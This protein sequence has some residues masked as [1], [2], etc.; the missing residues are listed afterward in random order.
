MRITSKMISSTYLRNLNGLATDLN[1]YNNQ[2]ASGREFSKAAE[3]PASAVRAYRL[4]ENLSRINGYSSN[5]TYANSYLTNAE[6][7]LNGMESTLIE[8][9]AKILQALNGTQSQNERRI[10][11]TELRS[12]QEQLL[13]SLNSNDFGI[14]IFG[15]SNTDSKP[16]STGDSG[17]LVYNGYN[18]ADMNSNVTLPHTLEEIDW[19]NSEYGLNTTM[20]YRYDYVGE[21]EEVARPS[22]M[23]DPTDTATYPLGESDPAYTADMATYLASVATEPDPTDT[24][25]YPGGESDAAYITDKQNYDEYKS[26]D[27]YQN[28]LARRD[29]NRDAFAKNTLNYNLTD[30]SADD[31][32]GVIDEV[33]KPSAM[34]LVENYVSDAEFNKAMDEYIESV[35]VAPVKDDYDGGTES[36]AYKKALNLYKL[37]NEYPDSTDTAKYPL[38][39]SDPA[40]LADVAAYEAGMPNPSDYCSGNN[41]T[42]WEEDLE[43]YRVSYMAANAAPD[44]TDTSLYPLGEADPAYVADLAAYNNS[45]DAA[46][47][48]YSTTLVPTDSRYD[49][50]AYTAATAKYAVESVEYAEYKAYDDAVTQRDA[51]RDAVEDV[52]AAALQKRLEDDTLYLD[53]GLDVEFANDGQEVVDSSVFKYSLT[54]LMVMKAG[55]TTV[56][57]DNGLKT[58]DLEVANNLYDM[59]G[60]LVKEFEKPD[61][62][63]SYDAANAIYGVFNDSTAVVVN[64]MTLIGTKSSYLDFTESRLDTLTLNLQERQVDVEGVDSYKAIINFK[65]TQ[66]SQQAALQMGNYII[67]SSIFDYLS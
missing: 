49:P 4:R 56:S 23:P 45:V 67:Q 51:N 9:K 60:Q 20:P 33:A 22:A 54:G 42:A 16:F 28:L 53:I 15:G 48:A 10:I 38:G 63:Y 11:A 65:T 25:T 66:A 40:Y 5:V 8:S 64:N 58:Y 57:V 37:E 1:K 59:L 27:I 17:Q 52:R 62:E 32:I 55:T 6:S 29:A 14:Y 50:A 44:P 43:A 24:A 26:Y 47:S 34:P 21:L 35:T 41:S 39:E 3:D 31:Y 12:V 7:V 19:A 36:V 18:V 13:Q 61:S 30:P 2:I 46:V